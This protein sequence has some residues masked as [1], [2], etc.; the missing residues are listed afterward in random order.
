[1]HINKTRCHDEPFGIN[2]LFGFQVYFSSDLNDL[3]VLHGDGSIVPV[4]AGAVHDLAVADEEVAVL[5]GG[6][7]GEEDKKEEEFHTRKLANNKRA[8]PNNKCNY[9]CKCKKMI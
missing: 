2:G 4:V 1:M 6:E 5:C 9:Q 8:I 3:A 7:E